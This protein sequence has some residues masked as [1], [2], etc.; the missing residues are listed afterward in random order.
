MG[1]VLWDLEYALQL[2]KGVIRREPHEDSSTNA[3]GSIQLSNIRRLP[4]LSTMTEM[5]DMS[6]GILNDESNSSADP[7]FS[8]LKIEDAR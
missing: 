3:S 4:S 8:Q 7:V 6:I 2:Q 1:D 5:D